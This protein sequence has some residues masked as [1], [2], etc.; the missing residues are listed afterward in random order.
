MGDGQLFDIKLQPGSPIQGE[1][2]TPDEEAPP[3]FSEDSFPPCY[4][5]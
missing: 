2:V 5:M 3:P 1:I 4:A